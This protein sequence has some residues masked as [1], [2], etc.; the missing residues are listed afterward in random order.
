MSGPILANVYSAEGSINGTVTVTFPWRPR[1]TIVTN[2]SSLSN[3][4]VT[5]KGSNMTLKPMETLTLMLIIEDLILTT[6]ASVA[7][8]VWGF[9]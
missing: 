4:V 5:I 2:D 6:S 1:K 7:Y 3:L 8:R 9:G